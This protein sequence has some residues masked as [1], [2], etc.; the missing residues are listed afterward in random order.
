MGNQVSQ[1]G[2][3]K[4]SMGRFRSIKNIH[5]SSRSLY[6]LLII[7]IKANQELSTCSGPHWVKTHILWR[8]N[9]PLSY[10]LELSGISHGPLNVF[11][12]TTKASYTSTIFLSLWNSESLL[13]NKQGWTLQDD[14][15]CSKTWR[16]L[17]KSLFLLFC[18]GAVAEGSCGTRLKLLVQCK[19]MASDWFAPHW[20]CQKSEKRVRKFRYSLKEQPPAAGKWA[21]LK[22]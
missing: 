11:K 5:F 22:K 12:T 15:S 9:F 7:S 19:A 3:N 10:F 4:I 18:L 17:Q 21:A 14:G 1:Q 2:M 20:G 13:E 6:V 16:I 8:K